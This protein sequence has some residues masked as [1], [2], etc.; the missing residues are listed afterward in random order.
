MNDVKINPNTNKHRTCVMLALVIFAGL[1]AYRVALFSDIEPRSDQAFFSWWVQGLAQADHVLPNTREEEG[2]LAALERDDESFLHQLL[3]PIHGKSITIFTS[4]PLALRLMAVWFFGDEIE[5]QTIS[6]IFAGTLNILAVGLL[7]FWSFRTRRGN[8]SSWSINGFAL[9]AVILTG[10]AYYL[11]Y[12]SPLGN[13]NFG[14]LFLIIAVGATQH[15][16]SSFE[17]KSDAG[18]MFIVIASACQFLALYTHWTNV[19][20]LPAATILTWAFSKGC[21]SRKVLMFG[22]YLLFLSIIAA[23][24]LLLAVNNLGHAG[25]PRNHTAMDLIEIALEAGLTDKISVLVGRGL[26]WAA[27]LTLI[28][29]A[30]GVILGLIGVVL[31]AVRERILCPLGVCVSHFLVAI[32]I[33]LFSGAHFRTDLYL[34]PFL[35][36]GMAYLAIISFTAVGNCWKQSKGIGHSAV[37]MLIIAITMYHLWHQALKISMPE[38]V[39]QYIPGFWAAYYQGQGE[40]RPLAYHIDKILPENAVVL[41]WGYGMQ[42]FIRNY[43]MERSDRKILPSLLTLISRFNKGTLSQLI[44]SRDISIPT[45]APVYVLIDPVV[46]YVDE[47]RLQLGIENILGVNGLTIAKKTSLKLLYKNKLTSIWPHSVELYRVHM[48]LFN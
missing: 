40:I 33:T 5:V 30:P 22:Y 4:V 26:Q 31:L 29:S 10:G 2:F 46:D 35:I 16:I 8:L 25:N 27:N 7:S 37:G 21:W 48:D 34:L 36:L 44:N 15:A 28:F 18:Y 11:H 20:L 45:G 23:P 6:S 38:L 1:F 19:F 43:G 3:R 13:H 14:V 24:F 39:Q 17:D 32:T 42:F 12:Y 41:T 47:E 9:L